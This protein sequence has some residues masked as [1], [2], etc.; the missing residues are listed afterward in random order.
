MHSP[1]SETHP[2]TQ[3]MSNTKPLIDWI[4]EPAI[5]N[6]GKT[7]R[8]KA[9]KEPIHAIFVKMAKKITADYLKDPEELD[10]WRNLF[11]AASYGKFPRRF[12]YRNGMLC[13]KRGLK[14]PNII[15][16]TK[17]SRAITEAINFFDEND[18]VIVSKAAPKYFKPVRS[19]DS[20]PITWETADKTTR[21]CL[22]ASYVQYIKERLQLDKD[23]T[24]SLKE[25]IYFGL[26]LKVIKAD[27]ISMKDNKI[28]A[29]KGIYMDEATGLFNIDDVKV[30]VKPS[31]IPLLQE[32]PAFDLEKCWCKYLK[33]VGLQTNSSDEASG[34]TERT[35]GDNTA[36]ISM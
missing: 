33:K 25:A 23:Q 9:D 35:T 29:I 4:N 16:S 13:H 28:T 27:N 7:K 36:D 20:A 8:N 2:P 11:T 31:Y 12:S 26:L 30:P 3:E 18:L 21:E 19:T 14:Q 6:Y 10:F 34:T 24:A 32:K 22:I 17:T 15:L 5:K 1:T